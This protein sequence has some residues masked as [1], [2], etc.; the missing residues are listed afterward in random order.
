MDRANV[1]AE[2]TNGEAGHYNPH[3]S[4][5]FPF[6]A[7]RECVYFPCHSD[8]DPDEFNCLFCYCPLY[9]LGTECGGR[10]TLTHDGIK[11]CSNCNLPHINDNGVRMVGKR[12]SDICANSAT[13]QRAIAGNDWE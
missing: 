9:M 8:I 6:F 2:S 5:N 1:T 13:M 12:F 3:N 7:H 4:A 10:F 11:D